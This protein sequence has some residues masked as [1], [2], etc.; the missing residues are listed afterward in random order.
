MFE[1]LEKKEA[2]RNGRFMRIK[3][4]IDLRKSLKRETVV[5]FKEKNL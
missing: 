1:E 2:H 4:T 5:R 3:V